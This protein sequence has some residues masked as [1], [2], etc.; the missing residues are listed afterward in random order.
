MNI[1]D[2]TAPIEEDMVLN[3]PNLPRAP[4]IWQC[5]RHLWS[6][7]W[8]VDRWDPP[9]KPRLFDGL[10]PEAGMPGHGHGVQTE[11]ALISTHMG[12]HIDAGRHF[13]HRPE[14]QEAHM[15]PLE[16][17]CGSALM[18]DLRDVCTDGYAITC[19]DL[20]RAERRTEEKVRAGDIVVI[21]TGHSAKY[22]YGPA[23][24]REKW[25]F[26]ATGLGYDTPPWFIERK[27]KLVAT[28]THNLDCDLVNTAHVNF[29]LRA[30]IGK[31]VIQIVENLV[32]L[33]KVSV[34]RFTFFA[35]PLPFV[36]GSGSP[37]RAIAIV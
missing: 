36:G 27:V 13:D 21:H 12:T 5:Q 24:D 33:E 17:C 7:W 11:Q 6:Q 30:W 8:M 2:L 22:G 15:I 18:L 37:V 34:H 10:P 4:V 31:E 23:L 3:F 28:D 19:E 16:R 1:I 29:L 32:N 35:L 14:A 26:S 20:D 9:R 25:A